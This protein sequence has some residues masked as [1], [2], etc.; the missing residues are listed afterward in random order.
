MYIEPVC[1][2]PICGLLLWYNKHINVFI[3]RLRLGIYCA[4]E[5]FLTE[6][7]LKIRLETLQTKKKDISEIKGNITKLTNQKEKLL[8]LILE[9]ESKE[10]IE[11]YREKLNSILNQIS[12]QNE[13]LNVY[14]EL[15]IK[16]EENLL[17]G[18]FK[19]FYSDISYKD[20]QELDREQQKTLFNNL[21]EKITIDELD[22]P[23]EKETCLSITIYM[24]I[25]GYADI[26][27]TFI[28]AQTSDGKEQVIADAFH[29][30]ENCLN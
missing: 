16:E 26:F 1:S 4:C 17:R 24:K 2:K 6:E 9:E 28:K 18:Q 3:I 30:I 12:V 27:V 13:L 29:Y 15:D 14:S 7:Q 22:I 8:G 20:F 21:I 23:D 19:E 5:F 25:P 10:I 11:T